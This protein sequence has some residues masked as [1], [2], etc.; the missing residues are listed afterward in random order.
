[1]SMKE[2]P[3]GSK[4]YQE[5]RLLHGKLLNASLDNARAEGDDASLII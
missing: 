2:P 1:V 3:V 5:D 4:Q